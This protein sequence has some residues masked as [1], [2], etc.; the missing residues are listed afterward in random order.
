MSIQHS[1]NEI[2]A[3]YG[4]FENEIG[5]ECS[6]PAIDKHE[7][8]KNTK[9]TTTCN[10]LCVDSVGVVWNFCRFCLLNTG[11]EHSRS[12]LV[13]KMRNNF[14]FGMLCWNKAVCL[15]IVI[16]EFTYD[17]SAFLIALVAWLHNHVTILFIMWESS[18]R[19]QRLSRV[20]VELILWI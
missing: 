1:E 19:K 14:I 4:L 18:S 10:W 7:R 2:I 8:Y 17:S 3:Q 15:K 6:S 9:G 13:L 11:L 16:P 12:N 5:L 20:F